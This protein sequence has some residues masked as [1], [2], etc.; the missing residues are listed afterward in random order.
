MRKALG[1]GF[2]ALLPAAETSTESI[3]RISINKIKVNKYQARKDFNQE[4]IIELAASIKKKG[5]LQPILVS[6]EG[7]KFRLIA[8]ERRLR[9][10]KA[11][12]MK[13]IP[14]IIKKSSDEDMFELSLI[15]NLQ[16]ENLNILE[17]AEAYEKL[18]KTFSLTQEQ[19]AEKLHKNRPVIANTL[20]LLKLPEEIKQ[21]LSGNLI[22]AGHARSIASIK[23]SKSQS[24]LLEKIMREKLTVREVEEIIAGTKTKSSGKKKKKEKS[25]EILD[26][27]ENLR[28]ALGTKVQIKQKGK[29]GKIEVFWYSFEDLNR[30]MGI[31]TKGEKK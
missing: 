28:T 17:E 4:K 8:G 18:M 20:R 19:V 12:D 27:E 13:E 24:K 30:I 26:S 5:L 1:K 31:M 22:S 15:E 10:A 9:A 7:E 2:A 23:N 25:A 6:P 14:A 21:A 29:K 16:R 3:C 11:A